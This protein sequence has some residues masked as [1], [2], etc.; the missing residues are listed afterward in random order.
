MSSHTYQEIAVFRDYS[1]Y[2]LL[3]RFYS[4]LPA[5]WKNR[6][7]RDAPTTSRADI[8]HGDGEWHRVSSNDGV[9]RCP[10]CAFKIRATGSAPLRIELR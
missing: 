9:L 4:L 5:R 6:F 3:Q 1:R 2:T 10:E 8:R 7:L